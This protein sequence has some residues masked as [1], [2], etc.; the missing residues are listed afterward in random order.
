[1]NNDNE[2]IGG[3]LGTC[4][5]EQVIGRGGMGIVY[6]AQQTRPMRRVAVKLLLP[7]ANVRPEVSQEFLVRF[8]REANLI[9][10]L[11]HVNIMPIHEYGEQDNV[12]YLVMPYLTGGSLKD[13]LTR[14]GALPLTETVNYIEQAASALDYAHAHHVIHRDLKPGNFLLHADGRLVLSD[15]GI[16]RIMQES[17]ET[18]GST[19]TA[20]GVF[21][22]T[23]EYMAPEM[24]LGETIDQRADIYELGIVLFQMLSGTVPFKGN[25]PLAIV[26]KQIQEPLPLLHQLN[27]TLPPAVD[28][29][30]QSAT[31]KKREDR[32]MSA[33]ALAQALRSVLNSSS[34]HLQDGQSILPTISSSPVQVTL[35]AVTPLH[36]TPLPIA[37]TP[38]S[39]SSQKRPEP[40]SGG[41]SP[42]SPIYP[43]TIPTS[44]Q[45]FMAGRQLWL[46]FIGI[47][48]VIALVIG[49]V[50]V[51]LQLNRGTTSL[52]TG[53][54]TPQT[55]PPTTAPTVRPT[56]NS[57][58][59][60]APTTVPTS[61]PTTLQA[62]KVPRG[63]ALYSASL[64]GAP[65]DHNGGQWVN[66]N[67]TTIVCTPTGTQM[68]N[69]Q[70]SLAGT[71]LINFS[72]NTVF[73]SNYV[74]EA[75]LQQAS[76]SNVDFGF[77]FRNQPGNAQGI[78]T[79]LIHQDGS[80][81]SYLYNNTTG[82]PTQIASGRTIGDAHALMTLDVVVNGANFTFYVNGNQVGSA[83][84]STYAQ[85]TVGIALDS[86]GTLFASNFVLYTIQ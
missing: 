12:A 68:S 28:T 78:Y 77:Y 79:F 11:E 49:G 81:S 18:V 69:H 10:Q 29:I 50:L 30:L 16:A 9:A 21:I 8:Q 65:C 17:S 2:L 67:Q 58:Q 48:L 76:S 52:T 72:N 27:P 60:A 56:A 25:T 3:M 63:A 43:N 7:Q 47:L 84:N 57:A 32:F 4:R 42:N 6:L 61:I 66:Y 62:N 73:P 85:G 64:P 19:L 55:S 24:V 53:G 80:W 44:Q 26:T 45:S 36:D 34:S 22:G 83:S 71:L 38:D 14:K 41:F 35:E 1:M 59:T 5:I 86:G 20:T 46:L 51:G 39:S 23:P 82:E 74:I 70:S 54:S 33:G 13:L 37:L 40:I 75:Q 31:A 15:F